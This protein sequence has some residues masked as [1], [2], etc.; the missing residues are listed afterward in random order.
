LA[1]RRARDL[2]KLFATRLSTILPIL[3]VF[4]NTY[5]HPYCFMAPI[6]K[7]LFLA[8]TLWFYSTAAYAQI[9]YPI[10]KD[11]ATFRLE[12]TGK[13]SLEV[14]SMPYLRNYEYFG[15]IPLSYTLFGYQLM[16]QLK[17]Q[18][19]RHF[20]LKAG[21]FLRREFGRSGYTDI[22]PVLTAKY[23]KKSLSL[24][25]GTLEGSL[26]HRFIEPVYDVERFINDRLEQGAQVIINKEKLWLDWYVDWEKAIEVNAPY[27]E[28]LTMGLSTRIGL[29]RNQ[30]LRIELPLQFLAAH[31]GGQIDTS[32]LPLETLLNTAVGVSATV[33]V[34]TSL[35]KA[36]KTEHYYTTYS[37]VSG[38]KLQLFKQGNGWY[39]SLVF[40]SNWNL[41]VDARYWKGASFFA[42]RGGALYSSVSK[43]V[44][45]YSE[46]ERELVFLSF[47]YDKQLFPNLFVD[48]RLEPYY[49][50]RNNFMEYSY[51]IF[52]RFKKDFVLKRLD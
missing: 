9:D 49:D 14:E 39:S 36:I 37:D 18:L 33:P 7:L 45:G 51:S 50:I 38:Q 5:V 42:P 16:P 20:S 44:P 13:L 15:D 1:D 31:K 40:Q 32:G 25:L 47:I 11:S 10:F 8:A 21:V 34:R 4:S 26:N 48:L 46:K 35:L 52:L 17:Y 22:A 29:L 30:K 19:N 3:P 27:R 24:L 23:Q 6:R 43:K 12:D 2:N 28:E 41:D